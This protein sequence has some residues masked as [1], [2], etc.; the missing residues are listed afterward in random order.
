MKILE[1]MSF[2]PSWFLTPSGLLI[3]GG[4]VLLLVALIV[5]IAT[6]KKD[7][8]GA[9]VDPTV[10][11]SIPLVDGSV[12]DFNQ[13][14]Q[15]NSMP[16]M[17][18]MPV[19]D[20]AMNGMVNNQ[21]M[22]N[23]MD[24]NN[25]VSPMP[26]MNQGMDM[27]QSAAVMP[28]MPEVSQETVQMPAI[29]MNMAPAVDPMINMMP[30]MESAPVNPMPNPTIPANNPE[31]GMINM[32]NQ[33]I[34]STPVMDFGSVTPVNST[35]NTVVEPAPVIEPTPVV[36]N[37][38]YGGANPAEFNSRPIY[39]GANPLE[40]T[41]SIPTVSHSAYNGEPIIPGGV[42]AEVKVVEPVSV[43]QF[44]PVNQA[45]VVDN[46]QTIP[47]SADDIFNQAPTP[48]VP[49]VEIQQP[50]PVMEPV[51]P[52]PTIQQPTPVNTVG[53]VSDNNTIETLD[54]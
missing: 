27:N 53:S 40:N 28:V 6:S 46:Q 12:N 49:S 35:V 14:G 33:N 39:G 34:Q 15:V 16:Q 32:D 22:S 37:N 4:V 2:D 5:F 13:M 24:M 17:N 50:T 45:A 21:P 44:N 9:N 19:N 42:A 51:M 47:I 31:A 54:F 7:K 48:V 18:Q 29:N 30:S 36:N 43:N 10:D 8:G 23:V 20:M 41:A 1:F 52:S 25:M 26:Q 38:I 3:T 11:G